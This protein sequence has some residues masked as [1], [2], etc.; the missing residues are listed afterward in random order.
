MANSGNSARLM[1]FFRNLLALIYSYSQRLLYENVDASVEKLHS[2][3][4]MLTLRGSDNSCFRRY[5]F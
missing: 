2:L 5:C 1:R 4:E 3:S